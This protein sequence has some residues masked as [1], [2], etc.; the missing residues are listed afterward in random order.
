VYSRLPAFVLGFHGCDHSVAAAV[1][2]GKRE[3]R[4]SRNKYD[5]L[6]EGIYFWE[7]NPQRAQEF[8]SEGIGRKRRGRRPIRH[9]AVI[10]AVIDLGVRLNLLDARFLRLLRAGYEELSRNCVETGQ[11]LPSN[12]PLT[13]G[14]EAL[15]R[16]LDCA[17]INTIHASKSGLRIPSFD[18]VRAAFIEGPELYPG[19][20]FRRKNHLQICVRNPDCIKGYFWPRG[21]PDAD[22]ANADEGASE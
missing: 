18:T 4:P 14:E 15:L 16:D 17:V 22:E 21:D 19:S 5:W 1:I 3:L 6:G 13:P 2:S 11:P 7:N 10:G 20:S 12:R 8:A 9:P